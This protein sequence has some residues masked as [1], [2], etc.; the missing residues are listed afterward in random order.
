MMANKA[1]L[2]AGVIESAVT[3]DEINDENSTLNSQ[4]AG[5][6]QI[7]IHDITPKGFADVYAQTITYGMFAARLHDPT[8][9]TFSRQEA[10]ELIPKSNPFLRKLFNYIAGQISTTVCCG[11][12]MTSSIFFWHVM[13]KKCSKTTAKRPKP[14]TQSSTSTR[15]FCVS[16]TPPCAKRGVCAYTPQPVVNF[17]V[18]A[19]DDILKSE[20]N[21][22]KA[23]ADT[24]KTTI[25]VDQ[26]GKKSPRSPYRANP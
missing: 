6:K 25:H 4:M 5:F 21:M 22:P 14:K 24:S 3:S 13:S 19:V 18:R 16:T 1:R 2:L 10:A 26:Q 17:I 11:S 23:L 7:L 15:T 12:L 20:F 8:L 9:P